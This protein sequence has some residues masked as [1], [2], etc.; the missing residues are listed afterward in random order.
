MSES[1]SW[2]GRRCFPHQLTATL[3]VVSFASTPDHGQDQKLIL[4]GRRGFLTD[5]GD[6]L[7]SGFYNC[8]TPARAQSSSCWAVPPLTP[9]APSTTPSRMVGTAP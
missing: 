5:C 9:Q 8:A 2:S 6:N 7:A 1:F 3:I 4:G